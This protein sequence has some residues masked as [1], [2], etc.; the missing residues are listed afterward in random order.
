MA[1]SS[2]SRFAKRLFS[3]MPATAGD[4]EDPALLYDPTSSNTA[5]SDANANTGTYEEFFGGSLPCPTCRGSGRV[6][7]GNYRLQCMNE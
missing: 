3:R 7:R 2:V 5:D 1:F 6:P 4:T